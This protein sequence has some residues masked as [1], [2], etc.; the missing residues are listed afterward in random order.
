MLTIKKLSLLAAGA[1]CMVLSPAAQADTFSDTGAAV[2]VWPEVL[3]GP[4]TDTVLQITNQSNAPVAAHCF[5]VNANSRCSNTGV[6][7]TS[8]ASCTQ[9]GSPF[10]GACVPGW[11]EINFDIFLTANQ[12]LGWSAEN[13][14]GG[15]EVPCQGGFFSPCTGNQGTRIPP[16]GET[17]FVGE[18]KCI[19]VDPIT[20]LPQACGGGGLAPC[21]NDLEGGAT[22]T[23][24]NLLTGIVNPARYNAVGLRT[25]GRNDGD[26][27]LIIGGDPE[28][29]EYQ[30]CS[31]VLVFNHLFDG[32]EDPI[33][34]EITSTTV[35]LVPCTQDFLAQQ[36]PSVTAQFLV[37]NEFEQRFS[38]SRLVSC[39]L[40]SRISLIDTT[41]PSRSIWSASVAGTVA[42]HTR[43]TG[44]GGGLIGSADLDIGT[45]SH[46]GYNLNQ[47]A[48]REEADFIRIP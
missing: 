25:A 6:P 11:V 3:V 41:Q 10:V 29:A 47:F 44:V 15:D 38:T 40:N 7:C 37:Y 12:P 31:E 16:V 22:I 18:L 45:G 24:V 23:D 14:L 21:R 26:N 13:G 33:S 19:Q 46:A 27:L 20:R 48:D 39:V 43:I 4:N 5:Y 17:P 2:L 30:P 36:I 8:S 42:G 9:P 1:V 28:G 34:G 32:A 35:A